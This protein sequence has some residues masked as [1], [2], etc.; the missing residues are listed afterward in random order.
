MRDIISRGAVALVIAILIVKIFFGSSDNDYVDV[1]AK[2][3]KPRGVNYIYVLKHNVSSYRMSAY[4]SNNALFVII[5][6]GVKQPGG[7]MT[8]IDNQPIMYES[9][10][11]PGRFRIKINNQFIDIVNDSIKQVSSTSNYFNI[12]YQGVDSR[13]AVAAVL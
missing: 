12:L 6:P 7:N 11:N 10:T 8:V 2:Y 5:P 9:T 13:D 3:I 1:S 4:L